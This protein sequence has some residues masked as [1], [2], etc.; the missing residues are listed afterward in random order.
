MKLMRSIAAVGSEQAAATRKLVVLVA[1]LHAGPPGQRG[2]RCKLSEELS[3]SQCPMLRQ[4]QENCGQKAQLQSHA[5]MPWRRKFQ[6]DAEMACRI[7]SAASGP[8]GPI[9]LTRHAIDFPLLLSLNCL[10]R[11][12]GDA[13]INP[14]Q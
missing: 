9:L 14:L 13:Q 7:L 2:G 5:M 1:L 8:V 3:S 4:E 6:A 10:D 12:G 11:S